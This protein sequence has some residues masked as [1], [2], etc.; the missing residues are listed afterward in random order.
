MVAHPHL[1]KATGSL[2]P[3]ISYEMTEIVGSEGRLIC[4]NDHVFNFSATA[5]L[6]SD[7]IESGLRILRIKHLA[8][9]A[10]CALSSPPP[11]RQECASLAETLIRGAMDE[12]A[13]ARAGEV[14][15]YE[16]GARLNGESHIEIMA[17]A[18][19]LTFFLYPF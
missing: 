18:N 2:G 3:T 8:A 11:A 12:Y 10:I 7:P 15:G 14:H 6:S 19:S 16:V 1:D 17:T 4:L 9:A 5:H 13:K